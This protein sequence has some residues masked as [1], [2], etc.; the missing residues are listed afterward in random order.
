MTSRRDRLSRVFALIG[1]L[2][3]V[4]A[5]PA[6]LAGASVPAAPHPLSGTE[7]SAGHTVT[8]TISGAYPVPFD[9]KLIVPRSRSVAET[10]TAP[11][12]PLNTVQA[13]IDSRNCCPDGGII[14]I[15]T[16]IPAGYRVFPLDWDA[17]APDTQ[18]SRPTTT[19]PRGG[20]RN[21]S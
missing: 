19:E 4:I 8:W 7:S 15:G 11:A 21:G 14:R 20:G 2:A 9:L 6:P 16:Q 5:L 3:V 10:V 13:P 12:A 18:H 17:T 1:A